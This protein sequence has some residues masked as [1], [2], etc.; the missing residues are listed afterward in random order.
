MWWHLWGRTPDMYLITAYCAKRSYL[1]MHPDLIQKFTNALQKGM[2]YVNSIRREEIA[3]T[4]RTAICGNS[5][6]KYYKD[7]ETVSGTGYLEKRILCLKNPNFELLG[8]HSG[9]S[10]SCRSGFLM[11]IW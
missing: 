5:A 1:A 11:R 3:K 4:I 9:G 6:G 8:K 2:D 10:R 7:C